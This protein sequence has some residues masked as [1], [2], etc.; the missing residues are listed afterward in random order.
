MN[1]R[2]VGLNRTVRSASWADRAKYAC[3]AY[4]YVLDPSRS[5]FLGLRLLRRTS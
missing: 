5:N 3:V 1:P 2:L 4:C